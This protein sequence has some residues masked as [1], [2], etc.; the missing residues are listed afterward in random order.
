MLRRMREQHQPSPDAIL[1]MS[2]RWLLDSNLSSIRTLTR[3]CR[4]L[5]RHQC[6]GRTSNATACTDEHNP[7]TSRKHRPPPVLSQMS[8][9]PV[10]LMTKNE[11]L[12]PPRCSKHAT[13]LSDERRLLGK[14]SPTTSSTIRKSSER[15]MRLT[16]TAQNVRLSSGRIPL[17]AILPT[18]PGAV[19]QLVWSATASFATAIVLKTKLTNSCKC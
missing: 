14:S 16:A 6:Q 18:V 5:R 8:G 1:H 10:S 12:S 7:K 13:L 9:S 17:M 11:T 2:T 19:S 3:L 15:W 4:P